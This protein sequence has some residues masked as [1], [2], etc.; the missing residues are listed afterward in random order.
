GGAKAL[1]DRGYEPLG[2]PYEKGLTF[3]WELAIPNKEARYCLQPFATKKGGKPDAICTA[4]NKCPKCR[5]QRKHIRNIRFVST[6]NYYTLPLAKLGSVFGMDKLNQEDEERID[7]SR[8][9]EYDIAPIIEYCERDV[10]IIQRA[11]EA[12]FEA[13]LDGER[14]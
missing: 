1:F 7:F 4:E 3:I 12:L 13:C 5:R 11:M 9:D 2:H 14:T 10:D 8:L 6:S